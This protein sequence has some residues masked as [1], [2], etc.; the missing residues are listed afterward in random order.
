MSIFKQRLSVINDTATSLSIRMRE[1]E[2]LRDQVKRAQLLAQRLPP[3]SRGKRR[4]IGMT[5]AAN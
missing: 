5:K 3:K 2:R 1:L 4:E